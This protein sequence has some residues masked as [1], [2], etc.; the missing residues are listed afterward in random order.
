M[1][2][3]PRLYKVKCLDQYFIVYNLLL[4]HVT[5]ATSL[6]AATG[7]SAIYRS[8]CDQH[9]IHFSHDTT[10]CHLCRFVPNKRPRALSCQGMPKR[11]A[12]SLR[13]CFNS[14]H[15]RRTL[16][17]RLQ[18]A[19]VSDVVEPEVHQNDRSYVSSPDLLLIHNTRI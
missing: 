7:I 16:R 15:K 3:I 17:T 6:I 12:S 9:S 2:K 10:M 4:P 1:R 5:I 18:N 19:C 11:P 14:C 8:F 13:P